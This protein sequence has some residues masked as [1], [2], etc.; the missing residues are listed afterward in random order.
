[1]STNESPSSPSFDGVRL[2]E[3][4]ETLRSAFETKGHSVSTS[5]LP[6]VGEQ[7]L[8]RRCAWFPAELPDELVAL[9]GWHEGQAGDDAWDESAPFWFRDYAFSNLRIA[10]R[11]HAA[12]M[13]SYGVDPKCHELL[14][15]AFPFAA[16]NGGWLVLP[17]KGQ[18]LDGRLRRPVISVMQGVNVF[19]HSV[20]HML[21]TCIGWATHPAYDADGGSLPEDIEL[22]IWRKHNP[23]IFGA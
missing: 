18:K 1:M 21:D 19:F 8:R 11:E 13:E 16:F 20:E 3:K 17:C 12:M 23:G 22:E 14:K 5:L 6:P 2:R 9:Y 4:L 15:H 7:D 10:E